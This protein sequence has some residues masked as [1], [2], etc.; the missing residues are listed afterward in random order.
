VADVSCTAVLIARN[1]E[2]VIKGCLKSVRDLVD[3]IVVLDTGSIDLTAEY[4]SDAGAR[5]VRS[6]WRD[7]FAAARNEA[8]T[9]ARGQWILSI[10]ADEQLVRG[11][12]PHLASLLA[13]AS[14]CA[15]RVWLR[16]DAAFTPYRHCRLFR[17]HPDI[18]FD[19]PIRESV[20]PSIRRLA[21]PFEVVVGDSDLFIEHPDP[22]DVRRRKHARDL[23]LLRQALIDHGDDVTY[24]TD[25][26]RALAGLDDAD[27]ASQA[28][29]QAIDLVRRRDGG[30]LTDSRPY[31]DMLQQ[32][33][34]D[35]R[36]RSALLDEA[37]ARF[38]H[39][40]LLVWLRAETLVAE[41]RFAEA[42]PLLRGL[43][44]KDDAVSA[45]PDLAYDRRI[46]EEFAYAALA[47]C[48]FGLGRPAEAADWYGR[49]LA[50]QPASVEYRTKR[51][52][53]LSR[54]AQ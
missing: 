39:N 27:G 51:L 13:D 34:D 18:R 3:E 19:G 14:R 4:A 6:R 32:P 8:I 44:A 45:C 36:G 24:W 23:P 35:G 28:W 11:S 1:E 49:A 21:V 41:R 5:V 2:A 33:A 25:L 48:C 9:H 29:R 16:P 40:Q 15:Y 38:P 30:T 10:D 42:E 52:Y 17:N 43:A 22:P 54:A 20:V 50:S 37:S 53:A 7:D 12:R 31:T 26:G 46:F 47:T